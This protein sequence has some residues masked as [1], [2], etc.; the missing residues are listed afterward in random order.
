M[1]SFGT[2]HHHDLELL[3]AD[4]LGTSE[5]ARYEVFAEGPDLGIDLRRR[6]ADGRLHIVQVKHYEGSSFSDLRRAAVEERGRLE[7]LDPKPDRYRFVTSRGLTPTQK[8]TLVAALRPYVTDP[9]AIVGGTELDALVRDNETVERRHPKLWLRGSTQLRHMVHADVYN[10]SRDLLAQIEEHIAVYVA[11]PRLEE[12]RERLHAERALVIA[13]APGVGKTA[14]AEMLI[15]DALRVEGYDE[16]VVVSRNVEEAWRVFDPE[17]RQVILYDDFLGQAALQRLDKNEGASLVNLMRAVRRA[18]HTLFLLTTREYILQDAAKLH[19]EL[20]REG[21]DRRRFLLHLEDC[22]L[23]ARA[24]IFLSHAHHAG[25]GQEAREALLRDRAYERILLHPNYAPRTIA[26][27][28]GTE[29]PGVATEERKDFVPFALATL[30]DPMRLW[31]R[32]F[33]WEIGADERALLLAL[34]CGPFSAVPGYGISADDLRR[35]YDR[36]AARQG[37]EPGAEAFRDA[38]GTLDGSMVHTAQLG[39]REDPR[40]TVGPRNGSVIDYLRQRLSDVPDEALACL[41]G[42]VALE[43]IDQLVHDVE[44]QRLPGVTPLLAEAIER[45]FASP[46][47]AWSS[48][49]SPPSGLLQTETLASRLLWVHHLMTDDERLAELLADWWH[50]RLT[51]WVE[52]GLDSDAFGLTGLMSFAKEDLRR[53]PGAQEALKSLYMERPH[54]LGWH[55]LAEFHEHWPEAFDDEEWADLLDEFVTTR[56]NGPWPA[57]VPDWYASEL[58]IEAEALGVEVPAHVRAAARAE[59][60][61]WAN[62]PTSWPD[63]P[64]EEP[65]PFDRTATPAPAERQ[66]VS[67]LFARF[68]HEESRRTDA[69][70]A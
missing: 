39:G 27:I 70:D 48:F 10:R 51:A 47:L 38:L 6:D 3:V 34:A 63:E 25:L 41:H 67:E 21:L 62:E 7:R 8:D 22:G 11:H 31:S 29:A 12:A 33:R 57:P 14:L 9:A 58:V 1:T 17:R 36:V 69:S 15:V 66:Q 43:Q 26:Q 55:G 59:A 49:L 42:T 4:L 30:D 68:A 50:E 18:P 61:E 54:G 44:V 35:V 2:L 52:D 19:E 13:G 23:A 56:L 46:P 5:G 53:V 64:P 24:A 37:A 45:A 65:R 32:V 60:D 20:E 16:P 40:T 28:V